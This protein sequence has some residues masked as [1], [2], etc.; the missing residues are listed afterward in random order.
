MQRNQHFL[1]E[2][3]LYY[4]QSGLADESF[5][6]EAPKLPGKFDGV[7]IPYSEQKRNEAILHSVYREWSKEGSE[8]RNKSFL[9]I[10]NVLKELLPVSAS[11]AFKQ[12]VLVP[13]CGTGRL[14]I[15]IASQG[16]LCE[17]NEFSAFMVIT[18]NF[19]L[20]GISKADE[21]SI[22]PWLD[23]YRRSFYIYLASG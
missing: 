14:A 2:I 4:I 19:M 22:H 13:G 12:R 1:R 10:V 3:V 11:N 7:S 6:N 21:F 8:E 18:S 20:N 5:N 23:R 9:P 15:E 17:G 16:Y